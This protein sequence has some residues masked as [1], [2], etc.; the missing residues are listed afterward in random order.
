MRHGVCQ[1]Q[2]TPRAP[3]KKKLE[4]DMNK[5]PATN[6]KR[7]HILSRFHACR[8]NDSPAPVLCRVAT[9]A[10]AVYFFAKTVYF[11]VFRGRVI[12][13]DFLVYGEYNFLSGRVC[14]S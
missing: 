6:D 11:D 14:I 1:S 7:V 12:I 5:L 4:S 9:G 3:R 13:L 2:R 10:C 8:V